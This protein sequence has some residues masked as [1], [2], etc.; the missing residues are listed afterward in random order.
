MIQIKRAYAPAARG[1]GKRFLVE[2]LWPRGIRKT[3]LPLS[4]WIRDVAPST[5]LRQWFGHDPDKW[6]EFKTRYF[7]ELREHPDA[8]A[9]LLSAARRGTITLI[10][11]AHDEEHNAAV[12]L[13]EYLNRRV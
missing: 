4:D 10:Y 13:R 12:A 3:D 6:R 5:E 7:A 8:V 1:D 11:S 9:S 2:R